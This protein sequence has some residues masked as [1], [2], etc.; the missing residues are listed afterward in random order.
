MFWCNLLSLKH[1]RQ[2]FGEIS[3]RLQFLYRE[4]DACWFRVQAAVAIKAMRRSFGL[5]NSDGSLGGF[6]WIVDS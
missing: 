6:F 5:L 2:A 1:A 3:N 4:V